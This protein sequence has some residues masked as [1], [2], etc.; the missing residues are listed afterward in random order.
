MDENEKKFAEKRFREKQYELLAE[1]YNKTPSDQRWKRVRKVGNGGE[2]QWGT[3]FCHCAK[4]WI[5]SAWGLNF[6]LRNIN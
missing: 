3:A 5:S 6:E 2:E 4:Q 1:S